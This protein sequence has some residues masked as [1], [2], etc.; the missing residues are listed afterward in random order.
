MK[1]MLFFRSH[2]LS[3]GVFVLSIFRGICSES[4]CAKQTPSHT[5][6]A[7]FPCLQASPFFYL[8]AKGKSENTLFPVRKYHSEK[9]VFCFSETSLDHLSAIK[10]ENS[11]SVWEPCSAIR[12]SLSVIHYCLLPSDSKRC[13][14]DILSP[15][16]SKC[17]VNWKN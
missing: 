5:P 11:Y 16:S 7:H 8:S 9:S 17:P 14:R 15:S 13:L 12:R 2:S 6:S 10:V 4:A 3:L 1:V